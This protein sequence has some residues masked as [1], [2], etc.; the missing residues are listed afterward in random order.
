MAAELWDQPFWAI[1]R[2]VFSAAF[3]VRDVQVVGDMLKVQQALE[4]KVLVGPQRL[5]VVGQVHQE[6]FCEVVREER[7]LGRGRRVKRAPLGSGEA[8]RGHGDGY[9]VLCGC[10]KRDNRAS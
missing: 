8:G 1:S 7:V 5:D 10:V 6:L 2:G 3:V 4:I 9:L